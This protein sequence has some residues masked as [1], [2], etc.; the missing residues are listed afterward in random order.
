MCYETAEH[1][2][3]LSTLESYHLRSMAIPRPTQ[4]VLFMQRQS[5][6]HYLK[7][8]TASRNTG[9]SPCKVTCTKHRV[10][11]LLCVCRRIKSYARR[12]TSPVQSSRL[13]QRRPLLCDPFDQ[14]LRACIGG[15][16]CGGVRIELH[17]VSFSPVALHIS[18]T[19][20]YC[21]A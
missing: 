17:G 12:A 7:V 10:V 18:F 11:F 20:M 8:I 5:K 4:C 19:S 6:G 13:S 2:G 9:G 21:T 16:E 1:K 3:R 15:A 14:V